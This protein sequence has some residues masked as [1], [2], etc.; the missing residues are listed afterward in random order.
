MYENY[1][2]MALYGPALGP[3]GGQ[4]YNLRTLESPPPKD[5]SHQVW[6]KSNYALLKKMKICKSLR[7]T[8]D[9]QRTKSDRNSSLEPLVQVS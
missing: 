9:R 2:L 5:H 7:T 6:A 8:N 3:Q 1:L 4:V